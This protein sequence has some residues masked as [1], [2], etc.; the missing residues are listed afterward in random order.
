MYSTHEQLVRDFIVES[1]SRFLSGASAK[2]EARADALLSP[3][4]MRIAES[5]LARYLEGMDSCLGPIVSKLNSGQK[6]DADDA[7]AINRVAWNL[8]KTAA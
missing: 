5:E 7:E 8:S 1:H 6:L 2:L 4:E 3:L